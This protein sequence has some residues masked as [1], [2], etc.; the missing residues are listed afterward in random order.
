M[1]EGAVVGEAGLVVVV[2]GAVL[3]LVVPLPT[4]LLDLLIAGNI[5]AAVA[6]LFASLYAPDVTRFSS[7]PALLLLTTL[8]R[9]ALNVSSTRLILSQGDAGRVIDAFGEFVVQGNYVVGA[10]IFVIITI[11]QFAVVARGAE[12]VS[13]VAARFTLDALPGKQLAIDADIRAGVAGPATTRARRLELE[14]EARMFGAMDGAMKFVRG[15][16]MA[17]L[18]ITFVNVG[19]GIV[20]GVT[21]MKLTLAEAVQ[22]FTVLSI[23]DGLVSQ[24]PALL[25][26]TAAAVVVTRVDRARGGAPHLG[27]EIV[28]QVGRQPR[29]VALAGAVLL[30]LAL[31]PGF[32]TTP[33]AVMGAAAVLVARRAARSVGARAAGVEPL[34]LAVPAD[35]DHDAFL[36]TVRDVQVQ[37]AAALGLTFPVCV[38]HQAPA[39]GDVVLRIEGA[40]ARRISRACAAPDAAPLL[41]AA[42]ELYAPEL[43]DLQ[44]VERLV[45]QARV[46]HPAA[47]GAAQAAGVG[48]LLVC[49]VLRRLVA[50][51]VCIGDLPRILG[52]LAE[53]GGAAGPDVLVEHVRYALRR[54]LTEPFIDGRGCLRAYSVEPSI[55][56]LIGGAVRAGDGRSYLALSPALVQELIG[57]VRTRVA[58]GERGLAPVLVVDGRARAHLWRL[59]APELPDVAVLGRNEVP[60]G[61]AFEELGRVV[62]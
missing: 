51:R 33:F 34:E 49:E 30:G 46:T 23:G 35:L 7:F 1:G 47:V 29:A 25:I 40:V 24:L 43:L 32:P 44:T 19:A 60:P 61:I 54:Q 14:Q 9:L 53:R 59:L 31:L 50:E 28:A 36:A 16:A 37:V 26:A 41:R 3:M 15:D 45:E 39:G 12:R 18:A 10:V 62:M 58:G 17:A 21:Q 2:V 42:L 52:A 13:E 55:E 20:I 8:F 11:V 56:E 22:T 48:P 5:A 57:A 27:A 6:I 38:V 4:A